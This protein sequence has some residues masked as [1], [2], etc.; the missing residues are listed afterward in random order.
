M[1]PQPPHAVSHYGLDE[2]PIKHKPIEWCWSDHSKPGLYNSCEWCNPSG[3][4]SPGAMLHALEIK[5]KLAA[6]TEGE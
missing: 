2:C 3:H 4:S 6:A 1:T 5:R